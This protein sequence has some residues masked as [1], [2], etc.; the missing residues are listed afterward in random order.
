MNTLTFKCAHIILFYL[1]NLSYITNQGKNGRRVV[2][3]KE[4]KL[5]THYFKIKTT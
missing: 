1:S 2:F 4:I 5:K 3:C